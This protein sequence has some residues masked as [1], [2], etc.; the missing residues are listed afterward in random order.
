MRAMRRAGKAKA[1]ACAGC[2]GAEGVSANLP[3]PT[4]A[5]QN[6][7]YL[8]GALKAYGTGARNDPMMSALARA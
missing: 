6:A 1:A 5:G 8:V 4:L 2:H 7:A 3:G